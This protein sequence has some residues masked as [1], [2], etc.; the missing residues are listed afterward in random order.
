[1]CSPDHPTPLFDETSPLY[2][3]KV[4]PIAIKWLHNG[5]VIENADGMRRDKR[6]IAIIDRFY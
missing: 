3:L 1:M 5:Q 6:P 2:Y 4:H